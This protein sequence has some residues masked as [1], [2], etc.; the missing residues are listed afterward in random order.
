MRPYLSSDDEL[1]AGALRRALAVA[2]GSYCAI[3]ERPLTSEGVV[4]D[5]ERR[6]TSS[7]FRPEPG[8]GQALLLC[9]NCDRAQARLNP[10]D[11]GPIALPNVDVTFHLGGDSPIRYDLVEV[12]VVEHANVDGLGHD[13]SIDDAEVVS[14]YPASIALAVGTTDGAQAAVATFDLNR[15]AEREGRLR[16][17]QDSRDLM[18]DLRLVLRTQAWFAARLVSSDLTA[19]STL[20]ELLQ[21][22]QAMAATG[23]PSVWATV[24]RDSIPTELLASIVGLT[25]LEVGDV[26]SVPSA[27]L[28]LAR[29]Q[30][31]P[32]T[33][34]RWLT[35]GS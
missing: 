9:P 28:G 5:S 31:F 22:R 23:F 25:P 24:L 29:Q 19:G 4:W 10:A 18:D 11:M 3:C 1:E 26:D 16:V 35:N 8:L 34:P 15:G 21:V 30:P 20:A 13:R 6:V 7:P 14:S 17:R 27:I 32:G 2:R 12:E 33:D